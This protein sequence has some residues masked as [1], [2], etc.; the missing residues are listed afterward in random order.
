MEKLQKHLAKLFD[1]T[2]DVVMGLP[3][4]MLIGQEKIYLENHRGLNLYQKDKIKI[5]I[6]GG[7]LLVKG[8]SLIIEEIASDSLSITGKIDTLSYE[9]LGGRQVD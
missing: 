4:I 2:P 9:M 5:K 8:Q 6:K 7:F 1:L 3:L